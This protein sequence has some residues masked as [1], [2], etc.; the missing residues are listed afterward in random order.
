MDSAAR[1]RAGALM[2]PNKTRAPS[3]ANWTAVSSP[4]PL[5]R[6][7]SAAWTQTIASHHVVVMSGARIEEERRRSLRHGERTIKGGTVTRLTNEA[8]PVM[9]QTCGNYLVSMI[10]Q[11]DMAIEIDLGC[12][13]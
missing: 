4:I 1:W 11:L 6:L 9:M 7:S 8:A 13:A 10:I 3:A 2:S 5:C 12:E